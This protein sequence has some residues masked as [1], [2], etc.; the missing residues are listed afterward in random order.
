MNGDEFP[1]LLGV[2]HR[3]GIIGPAA[4]SAGSAQPG[5]R[6]RKNRST[7]A[8]RCNRWPRCWLR[9]GRPTA[10]PRAGA[11]ECITE[12]IAPAHTAHSAVF[13]TDHFAIWILF[14]I[15]R[16]IDFAMNSPSIRI[17]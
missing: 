11:T 6:A 9:C 10:A 12:R 5:G 2:D 1:K 17:V 4:K 8:V 16:K 7:A 15:V 3:A 14:T 13:G